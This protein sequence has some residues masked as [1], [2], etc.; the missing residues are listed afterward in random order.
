MQQSG[1][2]PRVRTDARKQT[3]AHTYIGIHH[4]QEE[5]KAN[6]PKAHQLRRWDML[7]MRCPAPCGG[8]T[9]EGGQDD[10]CVGTPA[11]N[12]ALVLKLQRAAGARNVHVSRNNRTSSNLLVLFSSDPI[13]I[14]YQSASEYGAA[15]FIT[16]RR[17]AREGEARG[18]EV[19]H[20][21]PGLSV[22]FAPLARLSEEGSRP[23]WLITP[24]A[25]PNKTSTMTEGGK[26][27]SR[28]DRVREVAP[29]SSLSDCSIG[30][31]WDHAWMRIADPGPGKFPRC[32]LVTRTGH[33]LAGANTRR[34]WLPELPATSHPTSCPQNAQGTEGLETALSAACIEHAKPPSAEKTTSTTRPWF[35]LMSAPVPAIFNNAPSQFRPLWHPK[36]GIYLLHNL[37][38]SV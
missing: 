12:K 2:P 27:E 15:S 19:Y 14:G 13:T 3:H 11:A 24:S 28:R 5:E 26:W 25:V 31:A 22:R 32:G 9:A 7:D 23:T 18:Q 21:Q 16:G 36:L 37:R 17:D 33:R 4:A 38:P 6:Q 20:I 1:V 30:W 29:T 34:G 35:S 8:W 10:G